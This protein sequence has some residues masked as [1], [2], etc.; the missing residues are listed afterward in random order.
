MNTAPTLLESLLGVTVNGKKKPLLRGGACPSST[1][2]LSLTDTNL[3]Y[4]YLDQDGDTCMDQPAG[5]L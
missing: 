1:I 4:A 2:Y 3:I 5:I